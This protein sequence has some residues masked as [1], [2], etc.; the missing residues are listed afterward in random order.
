MPAP[1]EAGPLLGAILLLVGLAFSRTEPVPESPAEL[2]EIA[3][4]AS[5]A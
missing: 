3:A 5:L 1:P 2:A 4:R